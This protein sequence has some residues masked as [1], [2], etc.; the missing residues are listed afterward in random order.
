MSC[1]SGKS[2]VLAYSD[3]F[4]WLAIYDYEL[5]SL[6]SDPLDASSAQKPSLPKI[7]F[8]LSLGTCPE[9]CQGLLKKKLFLGSHVSVGLRK[10]GRIATCRVCG[11]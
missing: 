6:N 8:L 10:L 3:L 7:P 5:L 11:S 4:R 9:V 1:L 2:V